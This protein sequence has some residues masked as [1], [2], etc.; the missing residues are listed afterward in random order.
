MKKSTS[1]GIRPAYRITTEIN[2]SYRFTVICAHHKQRFED[3][4]GRNGAALHD[5]YVT[6]SDLTR[7]YGGRFVPTTPSFRFLLFERAGEKCERCAEPLD[8]LARKTWQID[9]CVPVCKGGQSSFANAQI[10]CV[11]CH[12]IKSKFD[13]AAALQLAAVRRRANRVAN[14]SAPRY[15]E[16]SVVTFYVP[17]LGALAPRV[18]AC[19]VSLLS[20]SPAL[21]PAPSFMSGIA[22]AG[23][24]AL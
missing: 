11:P 10:L 15:P 3:F 6:L 7:V 13:T 19:P 22:T 18:V 5:L 9:H 2:D 17:I 16:S 1:K 20:G 14:K 24:P 8:V 4:A 12:V 23:A 21:S